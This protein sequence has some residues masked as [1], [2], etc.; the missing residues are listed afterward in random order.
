ML[1]FSHVLLFVT[2]WTAAYRFSCPSPSPGVC[3]NSCPLIDSVMPSNHLIFF[4]SCHQSIPE[5]DY[6]LRSWLFASGGQSIGVSASASILSMNIQGWFPLGLTAL[7]SLQSKGLS[8]VFSN[9][10][11]R[12]HQFFGSQPSLWSNPHIH[13]WLLEKL[14]IWL[15]G[16]L[17]KKSNVSAF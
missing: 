16:P 10:T 12:K 15:Y 14:L 11:F 1:L 7:I 9:T 13:S 8:R 4:F 2:P 5:S 3:S 17:W 6:F